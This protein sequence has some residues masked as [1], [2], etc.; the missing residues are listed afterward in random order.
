MRLHRSE[1]LQHQWYSLP[2]EVRRFVEALKTNPN[3][4][5]ALQIKERPGRQEEFVLGYWIIW[6]TDK[7][8]S[9]TIIRVTIAE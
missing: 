8:G 3:P 4:P 9:E 6:E 5:G 2:A 1:R 7:G